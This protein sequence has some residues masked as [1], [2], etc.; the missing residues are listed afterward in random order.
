MFFDVKIKKVIVINKNKPIEQRLNILASCFNE[1]DLEGM[2]LL[3][4]LRDRINIVN[5]LT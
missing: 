2:F 3:P 1:F 5:K 4:A